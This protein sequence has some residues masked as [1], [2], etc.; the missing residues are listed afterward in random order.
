MD[1]AEIVRQYSGRLI[2]FARMR[3][4]ANLS[5][6]VDPEDVVQSAYRSFFRRLK[7]GEF[8]FEGVHDVWQ[9]LAT[10]TFCKTKNLVKHHH[11][12]KRDARRD[13]SSS[14][15]D[16]LSDRMPGPQDIAIFYESLEKLLASLPKQYHE[17]VLLRMEGYSIEEIAAK[18]ER[19]ERTVLRV[20]SRVRELGE[21]QLESP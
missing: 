1:D 8:E 19:S 17:L 13:D 5:R 12:Q 21:R 16:A 14:V 9:L 15:A 18:V 4:P 20:L 10:I 6:R 3:L 7:S 11:R 2:A